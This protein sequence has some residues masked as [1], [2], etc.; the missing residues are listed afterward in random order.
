MTPVKDTALYVVRKKSTGEFF[1]NVKPSWLKDWPANDP[2]RSNW[3]KDLDKASLYSF[4]GAKV[5][6]GKE[7]LAMEVVRVKVRI[8]EVMT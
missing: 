6:I 3:T 5:I 2:R 7:E 4:L 1:K 8:D